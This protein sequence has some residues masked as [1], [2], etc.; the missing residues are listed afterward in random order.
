MQIDEVRAGCDKAQGPNGKTLQFMYDAIL[1]CM[2][3][4]LYLFFAGTTSSVHDQCAYN[5]VKANTRASNISHVSC[6][7]DRH[8]YH[9]LKGRQ[10]RVQ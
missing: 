6:C 10:L 2:H 7:R 4:Q 9:V 8:A 3:C 5:Q 1:Y